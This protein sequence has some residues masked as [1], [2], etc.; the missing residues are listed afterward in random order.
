MVSVSKTETTC[1]ILSDRYSNRKQQ[2]RL[3]DQVVS[4]YAAATLEQNLG[5]LFCFEEPDATGFAQTGQREY[6]LVQGDLPPKIV[7][8]PSTN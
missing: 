2:F 7:D 5:C 6:R 8:L 3:T 4:L 1:C